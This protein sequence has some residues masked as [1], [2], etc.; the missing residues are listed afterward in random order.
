M[1]LDIQMPG[2]DGFGVLQGADAHR[3]QVVFATAYD[4][5]AIQAF[6]V[7][8]ADYLLKPISRDR[9]R[10]SGAR[11]CAS[12]A[13]GGAPAPRSAA[14][15]C[16][17]LQARERRYLPQLPVHKGRQILRPADRARSS[18][19]RSSTGWSTRTSTASAT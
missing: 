3:P 5:Y 16:S 19:S 15:S 4:E 2:M 14:S 11:A 9:L 8:A 1:F 13:S 10:R 18:G 12:G 17:A 7:Q 6:E